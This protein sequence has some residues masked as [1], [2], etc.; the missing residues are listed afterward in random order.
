VFTPLLLAFGGIA[1]SLLLVAEYRQR[2]G[3]V[4]CWK[5]AAATVYLVLAAPGLESTYGRLVM[6]ALALSWIGDGLLLFDR[7][8]AFFL[9]GLG[10]FLLAHIG[11]TVA[12]QAYGWDPGFFVAVYLILGLPA[13]AL[14][15]RGW[16]THH[17]AGRMRF[18]VQL[19]LVAILIMVAGAIS[20]SWHH[21]AL[22]FAVA[23]LLF[24]LSDVAVAR[25]QFVDATFTNKL[26]GLPLYFAAQYLFA[27]S[28]SVVM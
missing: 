15:W 23:A 16:L 28:V 12:L 22:V 1:C 5:M 14:I 27:Y 7:K 26:W 24:A 6:T 19:Y 25:Q 21:G 18:A 9:G 17:V 13:H 3:E 10:A 11:F 20:V 2:A 8:P 4:R